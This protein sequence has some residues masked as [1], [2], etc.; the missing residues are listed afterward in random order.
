MVDA[1]DTTKK[2]ASLLRIAAMNLLARREQTSHELREK[3]QRKFPDSH[4]IE[5]CIQQLQSD[6]LQSDS[7]FAEAAINSAVRKGHG[8]LRIKRDLQHKGI[9]GEIII[10]AFAATEAD[11]FTLAR[12]VMQKKFG[13]TPADNYQEKTKRM[14]FLQ[15]RGFTQDQISE[16]ID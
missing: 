11:F 15:Y 14:R 9:N 7:R 10:E 6:G 3:L 5:S 12:Q 4:Q 8:E 13:Y 16:A 2:E 1:S